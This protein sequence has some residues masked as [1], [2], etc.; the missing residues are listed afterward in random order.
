MIKIGHI[1]YVKEE[2]KEERKGFVKRYYWP[3]KSSGVVRIE[4]G[5]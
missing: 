3:E 5:F 2:R 4:A 1:G